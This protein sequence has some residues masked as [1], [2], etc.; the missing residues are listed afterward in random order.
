[1]KLVITQIVVVAL[2]LLS[3]VHAES[4]AL[5][6]G[7]KAKKDKK[8]K[9]EKKNKGGGS[10]PSTPAPVPSTPRPV[11]PTPPPTPAVPACPLTNPPTSAPYEFESRF[12]PGASS[13]SYT[14]QIARH[15]LIGKFKQAAGNVKPGDPAEADILRYFDCPGT[16][17]VCETVD[18]GITV[19]APLTVTQSSV[20]DVSGDKNL[21]GKIAG[22]DPNGQHKDWDT[23]FVGWTDWPSKSPQN[24]ESLVRNW[25]FK[26]DGLCDD[27][28]DD[29]FGNPITKCFVSPEGQDYQQLLQKFVLGAV[30]FSQ[31]ADDYLDN[32]IEGKGLLAQNTAIAK[33]GKSYT[34]LEHVWDEGYG[35]FG[36]AINF[37]QYTDDE[38][39]G[40]GGREGFSEGYNDFDGNG[41]ID[42]ATEYNYGHS[43]NAAKRDR[44]ALT[45]C[46]DLTAQAYNGFYKG[47]KL[48]TDAGGALTDAQMTELEGYRDD[49]IGAWE[50]AIAATVIHYIN[51]CIIDISENPL[52]FYGYA[53][54]WSEAKGFAL[55]FQFNRLSP[56]SDPDFAKLHQ[57]LRDAPELDD[58]QFAGWEEDLLEARDLLQAAYNF[59]PTDVAKW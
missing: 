43:L 39:A 8:T 16:P 29:P 13:V 51:D 23:E 7:L 49:A 27:V 11:P 36:A 15:L 25:A 35:Y 57:L 17:S 26:V 58:M 53:K 3:A 50:K 37:L 1:M 47:R 4:V 41:E 18:T 5:E 30:A 52:N 40:K 46:V 34:S 14:G 10:V 42:L 55:S 56:L 33:E 24:P 45:G 9:K 32:D 44:G 54:H 38:I 19:E 22:N 20:G 59:D 31:G 28:G 6:R 21:V 12:V 2:F 48:I